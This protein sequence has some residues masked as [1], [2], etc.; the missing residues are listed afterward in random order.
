MSLMKTSMDFFI[1]TRDVNYNDIIKPTALLDMFQDLAGIHA[2][3]LGVGYDVLKEKNYAWVILYQRYEMNAIPPYLDVVNLT[4]WPKPKNRLEF[5]REYLLKDKKGNELAKG[6]S[7]W[8]IIDLNTRGLVRSDKIE[9]NGEYENFTN[10]PERCKRKLNLNQNK[11]EGSFIYVVTLEDLDHNGHMNNA[12]YSNIIENNYYTFGSKKYI[13][14]IEIAYIKEAKYKDEIRIEYFHEGNQI[15]FLGYLNENELC[16][17]CL[18]G[19]E[20]L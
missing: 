7:N 9:F 4:T 2:S 5:E 12:R 11:S 18:I 14:E 13:K 6:I 1:H 19:E 8:V 20:E 16:F 17:E 3:E 10:Y 15:A